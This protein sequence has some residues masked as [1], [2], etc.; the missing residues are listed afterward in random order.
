M[1]KPTSPKPKTRWHRLLGKLLEELLT[2]VGIE[3]YTEVAIMSK[4]PEADIL[5]LKRDPA[6]WTPSQRA[7]L[8]EGIRDSQA[9]HV[10]LEFKYTESVSEDALLQSLGYDS[11][12]RR[13]QQLTRTEVQTVLVSAKTPQPATLK[14]L[15]YRTTA[16][17]GVYRSRKVLVQRIMLIS[18]NELA[19]L[20]HNAFFKCF[21]SRRAEKRKA[22]A[23]LKQASL[24]PWIT[25]PLN[26]FLEGL[27]KYWFAITERG[28]ETM[29]TELTPEQVTKMGREWGEIF[30][31]RLTIEER[32]AGVQVEELE[33]YLR[34]L[35]QSLPRKHQKKVNN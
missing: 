4:P 12:Y 22:F 5:L 16:W 8:P 21:A 3:V 19:N 32:L 29:Q 28:D 33:E 23:T 34:T 24:V 2:P 27:W 11:F 20:P 35:K 7:L 30:L 1:Q 25:T 17:P 6:G 15:G 10:L 31:S 9:S 13:I 14:H 18:L 26:W